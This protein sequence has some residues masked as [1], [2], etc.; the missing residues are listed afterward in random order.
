MGGPE[1][2]VRRMT[3]P[4]SGRW[5]AGVCAGLAAHLG[6]P[7]AR[8][9]IGFLLLAVAGPGWIAYPMLWALTPQSDSRTAPIDP[10]RSPEA[11]APAGTSSSRARMP[12]YVR[13]LLVAGLGL[14]LFGA[15]LGVAA[16][17]RPRL[18]LL[19]PLLAIGAIVVIGLANADAVQRDRWLGRRSGWPAVA[20]FAL[21][22]VAIIIGTVIALSRD[23]ELSAVSDIAVAT[24][25]VLLGVILLAAPWAMRLWSE[26][27][28]ANAAR[29][30][31]D[32]R[33]DIAAHL[34]DSVLQTLTL[35]QRQAA[36]PARVATLARIQ[37]RELRSYLYGGA[38]DDE[39]TLSG[40]IRAVVDELELQHG[41]PIDVVVSGEA[42]RDERVAA[43]VRAMREALLNAVR[44]GAPPV[45]LYA[46]AGPEGI[47][48][49][50][51]DH[52]R[53]LN[54]DAI[55]ADRLGVRESIMGRMQRVGGSAT[56]RDRDPG[57]EWTLTLPPIPEPGGR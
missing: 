40:A 35:I 10:A 31:A 12:G 25:V 54:L 33:A 32:E 24:I 44:H 29:A 2:P 56:V 30:R 3:R 14:C 50:V 53:G 48:A 22:A 27:G 51:R 7:V 9:R 38:T 43:L 18:S 1:A 15:A 11:A 45:A 57:T 36:D 34:H 37:E 6:I 49:F 55:P 39:T 4:T 21:G 16:N 5:I 17:S 13:W 20:R 28:A 52:G 47:E 26:T 23:R 8:V 19:L 46:E 41:I 42:E